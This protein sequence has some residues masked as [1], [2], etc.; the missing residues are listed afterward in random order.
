MIFLK[1]PYSQYKVHQVAAVCTTSRDVRHGQ[2]LI[3][4]LDLW[5]NVIFTHE[6]SNSHKNMETKS[7][8]REISQNFKNLVM[9]SSQLELTPLLKKITISPLLIVLLFDQIVVVKTSLEGSFYNDF[10]SSMWF[11]ISWSFVS[12]LERGLDLPNICD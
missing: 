1:L 2:I 4:T 11:H 10:S 6:V 9:R 3:L 12:D 5:R 7:L 8:K